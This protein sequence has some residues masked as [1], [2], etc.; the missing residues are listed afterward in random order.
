MHL[1]LTNTSNNRQERWQIDVQP[2]HCPLCHHAIEPILRAAFGVYQVPDRVY[3]Q[4]VYQ[5]PRLKCFRLFIATY[6]PLSAVHAPMQL[7]TTLFALRSLGPRTIQT[8]E[9][10]PE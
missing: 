10:A 1:P 4:A 3:A 9:L 7:E 6:E 2:D 5:C 8:K